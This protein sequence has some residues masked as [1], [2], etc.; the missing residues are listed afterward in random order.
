MRL[1]DSTAALHDTK[2]E[3]GATPPVKS[4]EQVEL[5][6]SDD[7]LG[8]DAATAAQ[9]FEP[10]FTTKRNQGGIG[11]GLHVVFNLVTARLGGS[12]TVHS[13]LGAGSRFVVRFPARL[14]QQ[15]P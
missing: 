3:I 8:M 10:F 5:S 15:F 12:I 6:V 14:A 11:L 13:E 7:G 9:I 1:L 2:T 4:V